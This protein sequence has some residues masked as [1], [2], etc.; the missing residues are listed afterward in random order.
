M[1]LVYSCL[2]ICRSS[3][4]IKR[5]LCQFCHS[6]S[7]LQIHFL[8]KMLMMP[9]SLS[10]LFAGV[11]NQP[12]CSLLILLETSNSLK[13]YEILKHSPP[14][15]K[16]L[17][18]ICCKLNLRPQYRNMSCNTLSRKKGKGEREKGKEMG[19]EKVKRGSDSGVVNHHV[20]IE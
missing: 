11:V 15:A 13:W 17:D 8:G 18:L 12:P 4:T 5:S 3:S 16:I 10:H 7:A 20:G 2:F 19:D 1:T 6:N 14:N 9:H